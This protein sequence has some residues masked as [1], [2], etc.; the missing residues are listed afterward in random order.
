LF[1]RR[2]G[3]NGF[4][5]PRAKKK[6]GGRAQSAADCQT[7]RK[8][9]PVHMPKDRGKG[10]LHKTLRQRKGGR[11]EEEKRIA[12]AAGAKRGGGGGRFD[13]LIV[14]KKRKN[15]RIGNPEG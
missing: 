6:G 3:D 10:S 4:V 15:C 2:R 11:G 8:E 12:C 1:L 13:F 14:R 5:P 9:K 7:K